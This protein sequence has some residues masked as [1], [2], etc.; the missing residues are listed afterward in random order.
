VQIVIGDQDRRPG[1]HVFCSGFRNY[2]RTDTE[3]RS[4]TRFMVLLTEDHKMAPPVRYE[5]RHFT[6]LSNADD[7]FTRLRLNNC[8]LI[9][10][11]FFEHFQRHG[12]VLR[13]PKSRLMV[14]IFDSQ[15]GFEAYLGQPMSPLIT[16]IYHPKTN[17]LVVYDFGRNEMFSALK[18]N[19][20]A[21][22][23][24]YGGRID[25]KRYVETVSRQAREFRTGAN[26][27]TTMHEVA[28]LRS[29]NSGMLNSE[30]DVPAWQAEGMACYC[31]ATEDSTWL[32]IGEPN[33]HKLSTLSG[34]LRGDGQLLPLQ[35]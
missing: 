22:G 20:L 33:P 2:P 8:E 26:I 5:S 35:T 25:Q 6:A 15:A 9:Y 28:H 34:A 18:R 30:G 24:A 12:I 4:F 13:K 3:N 10:H 7:Q 21:R 17:R 11:L 23:R 19:A 14:A 27:G 16:G 29:F 1:C 31:E 32:G